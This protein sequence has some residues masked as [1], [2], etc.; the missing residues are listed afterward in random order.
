MISFFPFVALSA[1]AASGTVAPDGSMRNNVRSAGHP[2]TVQNR[3]PTSAPSAISDPVTRFTLSN[4]LKVI[5]QTSKRVPLIT[6]TVVY[7]VGSKDEKPGQ[8]GYA[9]LYEH[10]LLDGS[11]HWNQNAFVSLRDLGATNV[12]AST[13]QDATTLFE[14]FPRAALER[15][16]FLEADRMGYV[17]EALTPER[18]KRE[19]GVVLNEKRQRGSRP[20][21]TDEATTLAD[22]YPA[23]HPYHHSVIGE[24]ADL[25]AVTVDIARQWFDAHYGPSNATLILAGDVTGDEARRLVEKYFGGLAPRQ[26]LDRLLT[27]TSPMTGPV[28]REIFRSVPQGRIYAT[29]IAPPQGSPSIAALDLTAQIMA[30]GA[31]SRLNRRL[32][33]E[34]GIA[35]SAFVTFNEGQ[36]S[37]R[38]GFVIDGIPADQITRAEAEIDAVIARYIAEGPTPDE[39]ERARAAR[40]QYMFGLQDSTSG[41]AFLQARAANQTDDTDYAATYLREL[42]TATPESVRREVEAVYGR[43]GYRLIVRP[44]PTAQATPGGYDLTQGPPPI[45][46]MTPI[47]FPA[48]ERARLSNGLKVVLVPRPG[49]MTDS[50]LL[51]LDDAGLAGPSRVIAPLAL[52]LLAGNGTTPDQRSRADRA[53]MLN[54]WINKTAELDHADLSVGWDAKRLADG[55][56]FLGD[57]LT[58]P[59]ITPEAVGALKKARGEQLAAQRSNNSALADRALFNAIYGAGHPYAPAPDVSTD[60]QATEAIDPASL[61]E[62]YRGHV[63]PDRATLY[64]AGDTS[65]A[66]L[67]PLLEKALAGWAAQGPAAPAPTI[68]PA[69]GTPTPSLTVIDKPGAAQTFIMAGKVIPAATPGSPEAAATWTVNEVYGGNSTARIGSNLRADKGWTYGIG[70]GLYD[71]RGERRWILAGSVSREHSGDSVA[72]LIKEMRGLN[73]D[74][75]PEQRELT[76][77]ATSVANQSAAKLEGNANLLQAMADAESDGLPHDDVVREPIRLQSLTLGQLRGAT[78]ALS[79]PDTVHWVL[80]GDWQRIRDQFT[81]L[82]LGTPVV[83]PTAR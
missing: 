42:R 34:L 65:M 74:R 2:V 11:A 36:L 4:G 68:P 14:T 28:R 71:T 19:V 33:E 12:N 27:R 43:P 35:S 37:S 82:E 66:V 51:R 81:N 17:G 45:G 15:V 72:E 61:R 57:V 67:K 9:H 73:G 79:D 29:Y 83:I 39:L 80:V 20:D 16:L 63:R 1:I 40:T 64:I 50:A 70:S 53:E 58:R 54:G 44:K 21:G 47:V 7:D 25:E 23:D 55:V 62:W 76:R 26:P 69:H 59:G 22:M 41:K 31:R 10:L 56:A 13:N 46:Q 77:I 32:I 5:V 75:P 30:A 52:D 6:A 78:G 3:Q 48:V 60:I 38:M 8:Y 49:A 18:V 24:D